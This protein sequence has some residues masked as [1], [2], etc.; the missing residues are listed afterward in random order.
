MDGLNGKTLVMD[1]L[2]CLDLFLGHQTTIHIWISMEIDQWWFKSILVRKNFMWRIVYLKKKTQEKIIGI[3][4]L[5]ILIVILNFRIGSGF[6]WDILE[7]YM[8]AILKYTLIT[9]VQYH[10]HAQTFLILPFFNHICILEMKI[11]TMDGTEIWRR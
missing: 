5:V 3:L 1:G 8:K 10:Q 11:L 9:G 7:P 2:Q 4:W 6:I